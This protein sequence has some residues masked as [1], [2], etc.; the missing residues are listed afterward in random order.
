MHR[1]YVLIVEDEQPIRDMMTFGLRRSEFEVDVAADADAARLS[2]ARRRP[3]LMLV[4]WMLPGTSGLDLARSIRSTRLT[5]AIP[6]IMVTGRTEEQDKIA[7]LESGADDYLTKP[8]SVR[9]LMA[10]INAVLRRVRME[11]PRQHPQRSGLVLDPAQQ[12]VNAGARSLPLSPADFRLLEFLL[13]YPE[14]VHD[15]SHLRDHVWRGNPHVDERTVDVQICRLRRALRDLD[16]HRF[17]QT[18]R[19]TGYRFS[20]RIG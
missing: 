3:D 20:T 7:A 9:E 18:V 6:I 14:Q 17:I 5:T 19:G 16:S 4:D 8:F 13:A 12:R 11:S 2:I 10:R 1:K 15:R